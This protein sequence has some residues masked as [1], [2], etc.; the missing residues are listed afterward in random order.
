MNGRVEQIWIKRAHRGPMDA[1]AEAELVAGRGMVSSADQGGRRQI[2]LLDADEWEARC[3]SL[4]VTV[5]PI[6]RRA[7]VLLRGV[8]LRTSRGR[9]VRLGACLLRILGETKPCERMDEAQR[10]LQT[11]LFPDWGGGAFAEV[12]EGGAIRVGDEAELVEV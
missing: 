7:N 6:R 2:T 10:G 8:D 12:V 3:A 9:L 11:T 4:G 1:R 5:D